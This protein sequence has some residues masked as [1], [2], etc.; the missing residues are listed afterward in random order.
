MIRDTKGAPILD[1][2]HISTKEIVVYL[3][4]INL[5]NKQILQV[6]KKT[7]PLPE[8]SELA[9]FLDYRAEKKIASKLKNKKSLNKSERARLTAILN[10]AKVNLQKLRGVQGINGNTKG[11][12]DYIKRLA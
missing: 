1:K 4:F 8:Y 2:L 6:L 12:D 3:E 11:L 10:E 7:P 5:A 9:W